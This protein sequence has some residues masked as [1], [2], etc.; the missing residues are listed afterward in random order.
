MKEILIDGEPIKYALLP[1]QFRGGMQRWIE[2][3][4]LPGNYL[5]SVL[6]NNLFGALRTAEPDQTREDITAI[7]RWLHSHAPSACFGTSERVDKWKG[8]LL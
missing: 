4:I 5:R 3:G 1:A 6:N 7:Y 8:G 2:H